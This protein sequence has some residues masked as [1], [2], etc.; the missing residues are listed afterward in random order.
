MDLWN[1]F[2]EWLGLW[3][4]EEKG[5]GNPSPD[6][7]ICLQGR[8]SVKIIVARPLTYAEG[9][10]IAAHLRRRRLLLVN[11]SLLQEEEASKLV[12]YL[13]G[14]AAALSGTSSSLGDGIF[15]FVPGG[16]SVKTAFQEE[17]HWLGRNLPKEKKEGR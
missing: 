1:R 5:G 4:S 15:L 11:T 8:R 12:D 9:A 2:L 7:L 17:F 16:I 13:S 6:N 14:A 3:E 10:D